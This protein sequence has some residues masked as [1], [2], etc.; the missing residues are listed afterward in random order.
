MPYAPDLAGSALDG[1][2]ELHRL[3]GEGGFGRVYRGYDRRLARTVAI[4]VIKPW[5]SEDPDWAHLF[6]RETQLLA[7][8]SDHGIVQIYDVGQ[9]DE[10]LYYVA[11]F[12]DGES[13]A[14]RLLRGRMPAWEAADVA[15]RL[16]RALGHAHSRGI[17]HRDVKPANILISSR[18][19]VKV[20]DFGVARLTEG[21][22]EGPPTIVGT[23]RYMAPEQARGLPTGP[24]T[25]IYSAGV[26]LYE[27]LAGQPPFTGGS[28]VDLALRHLQERP[29]PLPPD[30]PK[31]LV[32]IVECS[33]AKRP[34][35]RYGSCAEMADAL[36]AARIKATR[37]ATRT[38][39]R[40]CAVVP[41]GAPPTN[42]HTPNP[43]S[44]GRK[45]PNG[46][47]PNPASGGRKTP[48]GHAPKPASGGRKTPNGHRP[49]AAPPH[50]PPPPGPADRTRVAPKPMPRRNVNPSARRRSF[51]VLALVLSILV[52]M[53]VGALLIGAPS[54]VRVPKLHGLKQTAVMT[55]LE[56]AHLVGSFS[57]SYDKAKR[58]TVIGQ[59]PGALARVK[60]GST[61]GVVLSRGPRPIEVPQ[62]VGQAASD[63]EAL[64]KHLGLNAT[65]DQVAAP[66]AQP[67]TVTSQSPP[68][69]QLLP[70]HGRV[71]LSV[72]EVPQW[73]AVTSF[74]GEGLGRSVPFRIRGSE[75]RM[76]YGMRYDGVC[77][78][79][80]WCS[81]PSAQATRLSNGWSANSFSLNTGENQTRVFQTGPGIY[82]VQIT[83][84]SD[85]AFW[86]VEVEDYY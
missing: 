54:Y 77:T 79:I 41:G 37:P 4:K 2:Y 46:Q 70:P 24:A 11:E 31:S 17:V 34:E 42:G 12:V 65:A 23:P 40:R 73:R 14:H 16:C 56:R 3:V 68:D 78:F 74:S 35:S 52:A 21:T 84:G 30:T 47:T 9:A 8:V 86:T 55:K 33:L 75:W 49:A 27:M 48:N 57:Q 82:Q 5:W 69:H 83:P 53:I 10:G 26:V 6:A 62:L 67:G 45:T 60:Q 58:G 71:T 50:P 13:L 28:S 36:V 1:R 63:A 38:R 76:V 18:G 80:F 85:T 29:P 72:A 32:K 19:E 61:I 43:A 44:G 59:S 64:L 51:G 15:E 7:K 25:D 20:S 39:L 66:G 81:G 22:S